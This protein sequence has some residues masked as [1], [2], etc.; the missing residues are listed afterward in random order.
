M[1][2]IVDDNPD[3]RKLIIQTICGCGDDFRECS[4]GDEVIDS[5]ENFSPDLLLMDIRMKNISG[6]ISASQLTEKYPESRVIIISDYDTPS[7]KKAALAAG[8]LAFFS[9]ENLLEVKNYIAD[10]KKEFLLTKIK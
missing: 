3:I 5:Y 9:K 10:Y 1:Y 7:F 6:L 4:D 2:L 8:A